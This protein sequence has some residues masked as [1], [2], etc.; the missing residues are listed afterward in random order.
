MMQIEKEIFA[1]RL[2]LIRLI[3]PKF[4]IPFI[5]IIIESVDVFWGLPIAMYR[6]D[7]WCCRMEME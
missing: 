2:S 5:I 3:K 4:S 7:R 6:H 1:P